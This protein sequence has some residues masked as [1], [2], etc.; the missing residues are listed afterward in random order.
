MNNNPDPDPN[1]ISLELVRRDLASAREAPAMGP[2]AAALRAR[3]EGG[4]EPP[5]SAPPPPPGNPR[6]RLPPGC[7]VEPLGQHGDAFWYLDSARQLRKLTASEHRALQLQSLCPQD[8]AWLEEHFP[9]YYRGKLTDGWQAGQF[10]DLLMA[11]ASARGV[12]S[13]AT[14]V[15]EVGCWQDRDGR[16]VWHCGDRVL[17]GQDLVEH[18]PGLIDG[19]VYPSCPAIPV[20]LE[21]PVGADAG[22]EVVSLLKSWHWDRPAVDPILLL[23]WIGAALIGGALRW[24]PTVWLTGGAGTGKSTLR[25]LVIAELLDGSCVSLG[26]A[27]EASLRQTLQCA[28]LAMILDELEPEADNRRLDGIVDLARL[29]ASGDRAARGGANHVAVEFMLR[30][31]FMMQSVLVAPLR[32]ADRSRIAVL[33]LHPLGDRVEPKLDPV[34]IRWLGRALRRRLAD[35]WGDLQTVIPRIQRDLRANDGGGPPVDARGADV[36]GTLLAIAEVL[37]WDDPEDRDEDARSAIERVRAICRQDMADRGADE[38]SLVRYLLSWIDETR[39]GTRVSVAMWVHRAAGRVHGYDEKDAATNLG[40][41]GLAVVHGGSPPQ[42]YLAI[43]NQHQGL[44]RILKGTHWVGRAGAS[45]VWVQ[46]ARRL[47]RATG[48]VPCTAKAMWIGGVSTRA[49]LVPLAAVLPDP[50]A[51]TIDA[52]WVGGL[53]DEFS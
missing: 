9:K 22:E 41:F 40:T 6:H 46:S 15:R 47:A 42:Q 24:R 17:V 31:C 34:R 3:A 35:R 53:T 45:Q 44:A 30:S 49:A 5:A 20:P 51:K 1:I 2:P 26:N 48:G 27:T 25:N 28:S 23:G 37:R 10:A 52:G 36:F 33:D 16:L 12:W 29:S 21:E 50:G 7:P 8:K 4:R 11:A 39:P 13:P 38:D 43:A 32:P 14:K 18:P 19:A